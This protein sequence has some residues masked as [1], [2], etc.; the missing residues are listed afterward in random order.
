MTMDTKSPIDFG[1]PRQ[2]EMMSMI[3][4][5]VQQNE[6]LLNRTNAMEQQMKEKDELL[7]KMANYLLPEKDTPM[8]NWHWVKNGDPEKYQKPE[9]HWDAARPE[10]ISHSDTAIIEKTEDLVLGQ[11]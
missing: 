6:L 9:G 4:L 3:K 10:K 5:L 2:A 11:W 8:E 7:S 1:Q